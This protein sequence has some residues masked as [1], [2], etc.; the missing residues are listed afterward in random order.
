MAVSFWGLGTAQGATISAPG[1]NAT[2]TS[3]ISPTR[4]P[5]TGSAPVSLSTKGTLTA[6]D[7]LFHPVKDVELRLDRQLGIATTGLGTCTQAALS[8]LVIQQARKRC[9]KA[10][11]GSGHLTEEFSF[12]GEQIFYRPAELLF[13]NT[14]GGGLLVYTFLPRGAYGGLESPA[15]MTAR[16][17]V[18]ARSLDV[19]LSNGAI[20]GATVAFQFRFGRTW[21]HK[22][23]QRS[24]LSGQCA[25]GQFSNR[26]VLTLE[27]GERAMGTLPQE[28]AEAAR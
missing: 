25:S 5:K 19:P 21:R 16:G 24:Y 26:I 1:L 4:L 7:G 20:G 6:T 17:T 12:L 28:C 11:V 8:G 9:A 13:F 27:N 22:G 18:A 10:L 14:A 15:A 2:V 3:T 23:E